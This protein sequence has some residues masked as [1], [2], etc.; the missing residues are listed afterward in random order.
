MQLAPG[1]VALD[2]GAGTGRLSAMLAAAGLHVEAIEPNAEMRALGIAQ[3]ERYDVTWR[4]AS[5]EA[6][7]ALNASVDLVSY[8]SSLNVLDRVQALNEAARVLRRHSWMVCLWNH[9]DLDQPRQREVEAAIHRF[10]PGYEYG[11]RRE[12]PSAV[13]AASGHFGDVHFLQRELV[14]VTSRADFIDG[15]RAHATLQRQAG[16]QFEQ[17]LAAI[18]ELVSDEESIAVPFI[19]RAWFAQRRD[20]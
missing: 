11:T 13:I 15:F 10:L 18:A 7:G 1:A 6:T 5:G 16:D 12:D 19:T 3:T 14:H 8:G 2:V 4:E 20:A 17:V 9:R